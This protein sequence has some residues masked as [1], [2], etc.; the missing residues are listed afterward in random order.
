MGGEHERVELNVGRNVRLPSI[1]QRLYHSA[2]CHMWPVGFVPGCPWFN[3]SAVLVYSLLVCPLP[4][5]I[6]SVKVI[7]LPEKPQRVEVNHVY[8][9]LHYHLLLYHFK[10]PHK[11]YLLMAYFL[12]SLISIDCS[13]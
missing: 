9:T 2:I 13:A 10:V 7:S 1:I 4:V 5:G 11:L 3:S 6:L 12:R 8:N